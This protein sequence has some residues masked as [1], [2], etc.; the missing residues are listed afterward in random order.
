MFNN[1]L[2]VH[3][4]K[5]YKILISFFLFKHVWKN[6]NNMCHVPSPVF[7]DIWSRNYIFSFKENDLTAHWPQQASVEKGH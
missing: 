4:L 7:L 2:F 6:N 1:L 3:A 5:Y